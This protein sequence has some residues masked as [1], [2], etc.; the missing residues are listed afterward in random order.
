MGSSVTTCRTERI[1]RPY[2]GGL[3]VRTTLLLLGITLA[4]PLVAGG[5]VISVPDDYE[6][7]GAALDAASPN[8]TV[9]VTPGTYVENIV[10]P[11]TPGI[12][13]LSEAGPEVTIL[14]GN[15][16]EAVIGVYTGVDTTTL[17]RGFTIRNG[18]VEGQ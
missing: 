12:K 8:D 2:L 10:W 14:D 6:Q 13:L 15:A 1:T 4:T 9:I 7:V 5:G 11:S 18:Y 3:N 16:T 17:I